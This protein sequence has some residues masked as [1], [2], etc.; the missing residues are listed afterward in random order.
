MVDVRQTTL[1]K[2]KEDKKHLSI[3]VPRQPICYQIVDK[4]FAIKCMKV[5]NRS[6]D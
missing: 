4:V 6:K 1:K 5:G 2:Y 3:K